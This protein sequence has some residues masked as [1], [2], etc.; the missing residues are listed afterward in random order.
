WTASQELLPKEEGVLLSGLSNGR[1]PAAVCE[2]M[3]AR[4]AAPAQ[5]VSSSYLQTLTSVCARAHLPP[6]PIVPS[7]A[8]PP[9][10]IQSDFS[11]T[12]PRPVGPPQP[13]RPEL[14]AWFVKQRAYTQDLM[15]TATA[16]L[17]GSLA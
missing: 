3:Q 11:R 14:E 10:T 5:S 1:P 9:V 4:V 6:I 12:P 15:K 17:A 8:S 7:S 13:P 16:A 2:L